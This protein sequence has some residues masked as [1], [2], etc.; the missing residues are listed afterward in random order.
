MFLSIFTFLCR[1]TPF[2]DVK[3]FSSSLEKFHF[4]EMGNFR[5]ENFNYSLGECQVSLLQLKREV[6]GCHIDVLQGKRGFKKSV[7]IPYVILEQPI[8][9]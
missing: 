9:G 3:Q 2:L 5:T 1:N 4:S 7:Q 6:T 8:L